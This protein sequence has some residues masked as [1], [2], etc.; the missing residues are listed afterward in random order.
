MGQGRRE[1]PKETEGDSLRREDAEEGRGRAR[2]GQGSAEAGLSS[3]SV[4]KPVALRP[5]RSRSDR[6]PMRSPLP[7]LTGGSEQR[8]LPGCRGTASLSLSGWPH[9]TAWHRR[10]R[11]YVPEDAFGNVPLAS[12]QKRRA[13]RGIKALRRKGG[14]R[15]PRP[16][17]FR[18]KVSHS[19]DKVKKKQP[20]AAS[21]VLWGLQMKT[22][23]RCR[24]APIGLAKLAKSDGADASGEA[25]ARR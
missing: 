4:A 18:N 22:T 3:R 9:R 8:T 1:G 16:S 25:S 24:Y 23:M 2:P 13:L 5:P 15:R 12:F 17:R 7:P 19:S 20:D 6:L 21:L 10:T 14:R 11:L